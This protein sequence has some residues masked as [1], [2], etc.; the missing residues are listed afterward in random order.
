M[1]FTN[2]LRYL[3]KDGK[4]GSHGSTESIFQLSECGEFLRNMYVRECDKVVTRVSD[5]EPQNLIDDAQLVA[6]IAEH[7]KSYLTE[8]KEIS[9]QEYFNKLEM[10]P[11]LKWGNNGGINSFFMSEF[12]TGS[13]TDQYAECGDK[14]YTKTV[15]MKDCTTWIQLSEV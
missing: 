14:Y 5:Y 3:V 8:C 10:L 11:P 12:L 2:G 15:N 13:I 9:E 1:N 6:L 4:L 7:E